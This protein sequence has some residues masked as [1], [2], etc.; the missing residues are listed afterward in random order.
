MT[1]SDHA[2]MQWLREITAEAVAEMP[3]S[4]VIIHCTRSG[5]LLELDDLIPGLNYGP[6]EANY[7]TGIAKTHVFCYRMGVNTLCPI[8]NPDC[9]AKTKA[10]ISE[11]ITKSIELIEK[12]KQ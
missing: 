4:A 10:A 3:T 12:R 11:W 8:A 7:H 6:L 2:I 5:S 1:D 9:E